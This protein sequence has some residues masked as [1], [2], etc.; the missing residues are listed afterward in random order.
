[1]GAL[2]A[3]PVRGALTREAP[4]GRLALTGPGTG[5]AWRSARSPQHACRSHAAGK[6]EP[7]RELAA[8]GPFPLASG[9]KEKTREN[10]C[11][12]HLAKRSV[13][14]LLEEC[15]TDLAEKC[16]QAGCQKCAGRLHR[17]DYPRKPR[18][19]PEEANEVETWRDSFCCDEE[20]CR[21]RHT[22]PSVRFL[23]RRVY[24]GVVVVLM[25]AMMHGI[26]PARVEALREQL[27]IDRRT[28]ERWRTWWLA[29]F[30]ESKFWK[31]ARAQ[32]MPPLCQ[33]TLPWSLC[34]AFGIDR[35]DRLLDLLRLLRPLTTAWVPVP[36]DH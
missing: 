1:M 5:A 7:P 29:P 17:S 13:Y 10:W 36:Q 20:G 24:W 25:A 30:V 3:G 4:T 22:P 18:G 9:V 32:F 21:K 15:D 26:K 28:L 2:G 27:G 31:E 12:G 35:L 34:E 23:G 19:G 14:E 8:R 11:Q 6:N 16:Q 33:K